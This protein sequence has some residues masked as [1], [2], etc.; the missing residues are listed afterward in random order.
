MK[1]KRHDQ[2]TFHQI[3]Q[4][5]NFC[6]TSTIVLHAGRLGKNIKKSGQEKLFL[7]KA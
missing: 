7:L 2:E 1:Q 4:K 6:I 5:K 3:N